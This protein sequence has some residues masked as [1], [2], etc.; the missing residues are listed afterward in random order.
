MFRGWNHS[1]ASTASEAILLQRLKR[2][3]GFTASEPLKDR[4][5]RIW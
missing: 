4:C 2:F 1:E 3:K 5:Y